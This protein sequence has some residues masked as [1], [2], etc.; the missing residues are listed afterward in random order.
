[1]LAVDKSLSLSIYSAVIPRGNRARYCGRDI[2]LKVT[3]YKQVSLEKEIQKGQN[4]REE[5]LRPR[6]TAQR[7]TGGITV[8]DKGALQPL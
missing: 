2:T 4:R 7:P 3:I 5:V 1:M 6:S 8:T